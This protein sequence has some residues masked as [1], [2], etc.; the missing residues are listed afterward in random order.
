MMVV[1]FGHVRRVGT[2]GP[3]MLGCGLGRAWRGVRDGGGLRFYATVSLL[4]L[5]LHFETFDLGNQV[6]EEMNWLLVNDAARSRK[7]L[8]KTL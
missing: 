1:E 7:I 3:G 8:S 2:F 5:P 6:T 4:L